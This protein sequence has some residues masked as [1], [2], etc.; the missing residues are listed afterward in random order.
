MLIILLVLCASLVCV[1]PSSDVK[2][3]KSIN[4]QYGSFANNNEADDLQTDNTYWR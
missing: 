4:L 3:T 1:L 2:S